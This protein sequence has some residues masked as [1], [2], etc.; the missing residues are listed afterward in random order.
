MTRT[1]ESGGWIVFKNIGGKIKWLA[2]FF[3]WF[4]II[5]SIVSGIVF[6]VLPI[7]SHIAMISTPSFIPSIGI[8]GIFKIIL[9]FLLIASIGSLFSWIS[10]WLLYGF[11]ELIEKTSENNNHLRAISKN[12][13]SL[14]EL[15]SNM[16]ENEEAD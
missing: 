8:S 16:A 7:V 11:G 1:R 13:Y 2:K 5:V 4:G 3:A 6:G 15:I 9:Q 10:S 14:C 12:T